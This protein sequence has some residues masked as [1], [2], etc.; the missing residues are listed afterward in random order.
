MIKNYHHRY[1]HHHRHRH[2]HHLHHFRHHHQCRLESPSDECE[3]GAGALLQL[4]TRLAY[5]AQLT[6]ILDIFCRRYIQSKYILKFSRSLRYCLSFM[7]ACSLLHFTRWTMDIAN[8]IY[9]AWQGVSGTK[10]TRNVWINNI[11]KYRLSPRPKRTVEIN[12]IELNC[13][14]SF[15]LIQMPFF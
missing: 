15:C 3:I 10:S 7:Y 12:R 14:D 4:P 11:Q 8:K 9:I 1:H 13:L 6:Q 2:R 5:S